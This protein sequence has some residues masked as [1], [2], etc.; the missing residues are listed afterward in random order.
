MSIAGVIYNKLACERSIWQLASTYAAAHR[1]EDSGLRP[2][3]R[4]GD[5]VSG[6]GVAHSAGRAGSHS[7][8]SR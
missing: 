6:V 2:V 1:S 3:A 8:L 4:R 7:L 5:W